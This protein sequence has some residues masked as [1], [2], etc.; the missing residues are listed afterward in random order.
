MLI[1][2]WIITDSLQTSKQASW[3]AGY[4]L[5]ADNTRG[6]VSD[7]HKKLQLLPECSFSILL[8]TDDRNQ[9]EINDADLEKIIGL[10]F[11]PCY[12]L[13]NHQ[14]IVFLQG[15]KTR[16]LNS[17]DR[18]VVKGKKQGLNVSILEIKKNHPDDGDN[19]FAYQLPSPDL[20]YDLLIN[21]WLANC[22]SDNI[23]GEIHLLIS[24]K[25]HDL[26]NIMDNIVRNEKALN[27]TREY[28]LARLL[29]EKQRLIDD[30]KHDLDLKTEAEN[31]SRL[32]MI[33]QKELAKEN[34]QWYY[35][36]YEILPGWYKKFGHF[37]KVLMGKRRARSLF[38]N[39][40][41]KYRH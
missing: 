28:K 8:N 33:I 22:T 31:N 5:S 3:L 21:N 19:Q 9:E 34:V 6:D 7:L 37:V 10:F 24:E 36:E 23:A 12:Y 1:N 13:Y 14:P 35:N 41:K 26:S 25:E 30:Y 18:L 32:N 38:S 40:A 39:N 29:Y 15:N 11:Q 27:E 20:S 2:K 4:C 16:L 17:C